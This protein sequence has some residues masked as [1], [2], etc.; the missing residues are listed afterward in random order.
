MIYIFCIVSDIKMAVTTKFVTLDQ[1]ILNR[2]FIQYKHSLKL[3][4]G[5][6]YCS[7]HYIKFDL[8]LNLLNYYVLTTYMTQYRIRN[9]MAVMSFCLVRG[10]TPNFW[11]R[12]S[13]VGIATGYGLDDWG[14]GVRIP[15]GLRHFFSPRRPDRL[16]GP[17]NLLSNEYLGLFPRG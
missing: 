12:G 6:T 5:V 16:W 3:C 13:V 1:N 10:T 4:H 8:Y 2:L 9:I 14:V 11:S 17:H 15:V 7:H